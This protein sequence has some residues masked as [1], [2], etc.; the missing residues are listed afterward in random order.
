MEKEVKR[1]LR[2]GLGDRYCV[3]VPVYYE[4]EEKPTWKKV[5]E[6]TKEECEKEL[7][8]FPDNLKATYEENKKNKEIMIDLYNFFIS[9]HAYNDAEKIKKRYH[10]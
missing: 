6:G 8:L 7:L 10:L 1:I 3:S 4:Y 5:F 9:I 2:N